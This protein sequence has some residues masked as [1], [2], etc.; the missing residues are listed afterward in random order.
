[1]AD[2]LDMIPGFRDDAGR[3]E[4]NA[5]AAHRRL[6]PHRELRLDAPAL[7]TESVEALDAVLG[8]EPV[9][10][11]IP[12]AVATG[13]ARDRIRMSH[14]PGDQVAAREAAAWRRRFDF[15]ER[16]VTED[17]SRLS[18]RRRPV[19]AREDFTICAADADS[20]RACKH[21]ALILRR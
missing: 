14:D 4:Q 10:T 19:M 18:R 2:A 15:S 21:C 5:G 9:A 12:F 16:L 20:E 7:G 1:M 3:L 8:V 11:H 13:F 17:E 6:E